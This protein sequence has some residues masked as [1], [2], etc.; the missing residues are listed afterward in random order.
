MKL[1]EKLYLEIIDLF[2][3]GKLYEEGLRMCK[4]LASEYENETFDFNQL[5]ELHR[6]MA[7]FYDHIM[8][9]I[10]PKP[11]YYRV[12]YYGKAF[13]NLLQNKTF[14]YKAKPYEKLFEFRNE[15]LSQ[16]PNA[17]LLESLI[18][19]G[20]ETTEANIQSIL[21]NQVEPVMNE[22]TK[23][24]F[25]N[26]QVNHQIQQY[27]EANEVQVFC[28]SRKK[29][30][31]IESL[32]EENEFANMWLERTYLTTSYPLPGILTWFPVLTTS[33]YSLSPIE[34]AIETMEK[35]NAKLKNTILQ[36]MNDSNLQISP[37]TMKLNG[38]LDPA[39]N[40]GTAKYEEVFFTE[41]YLLKHN[42]SKEEAKI[43]KLKTLIAEQIPLLEIAIQVH[44]E[45]AD[46]SMQPLHNRLEELFAKM[47]ES[48][49][50]KYGEAEVPKELAQF[51]LIKIRNLEFKNRQLINRYSGTE[52]ISQHQ[53][54][55]GKTN[56]MQTQ[57]SFELAK[58]GS[59]L[60]LTN[61][62]KKTKSAFVRSTNGQSLNSTTFH[63][64][65]NTGTSTLTKFRPKHKENSTTNGSTNQNNNQQNNGSRKSNHSTFYITEL[66]EENNNNNNTACSTAN[67]AKSTNDLR[68]GNNQIVLSEKLETL[69]PRKSNH[70][71]K[72]RSNSR[73]SSGSNYLQV[74]KSIS[75]GNSSTSLSPDSK[76]EESTASNSLTNILN[77]TSSIEN[78]L[79]NNS[80]VTSPPLP[81][82]S[83]CLSNQI[84]SQ[85]SINNQSIEINNELDEKPPP[86]PL[87]HHSTIIENKYLDSNTSPLKHRNSCSSL[88]LPKKKLPP[89]LPTNHSLSSL[90]QRTKSPAKLNNGIQN[91]SLDQHCESINN[92][93]HIPPLRKKLFRPVP[94]LPTESFGESVKEMNG[95][96]N[97][98]STNNGET[99]V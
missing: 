3:K 70:C 53:M 48:I 16:F 21:I 67:K 12:S 55:N 99:E 33:S 9:Q 96:T 81:P 63:S 20:P 30:I 34:N 27:Y 8:K 78:N 49:Q 90:D 92:Y 38:I 88:S 1:K 29:K 6:Q 75:Q 24:K 18:T 10:R 95:G 52:S 26:K 42:T 2:D 79:N 77:N 72:Q 59:M 46:A 31:Q 11:E 17:T 32:N 28:Y 41:N 45:R 35:S 71:E 39:V 73:P 14:I 69:R 94:P 97:G 87:K 54:V 93:E 22:R 7:I 4:E 86:L 76:S 64:L 66:T 89:P 5:S 65:I 84:S 58:H 47:K 23:E 25:A 43:N 80:M 62:V 61:T 82:S 85:S 57:S 56:Q 37:L 98:C 40:G 91:V 60:S 44:R 74:Y 13:S 83:N 15:L 68:N 19:P 51:N 36:H 50:K